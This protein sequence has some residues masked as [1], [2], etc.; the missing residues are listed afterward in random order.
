MEHRQGRV[1]LPGVRFCQ[2]GVA[3]LG[4]RPL[5]E[6]EPMAELVSTAEV[7]ELPH[8]GAWAL[9]LAPGKDGAADLPFSCCLSCA[10]WVLEKFQGCF[11]SL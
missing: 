8:F 10:A 7:S 6:A 4:A 9:A 2:G 1:L 5:Y 11:G 3:E